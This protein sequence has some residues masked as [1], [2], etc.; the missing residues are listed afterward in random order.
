MTAAEY[1]A[2]PEDPDRNYELQDGFVIVSAKPVPNHQHAVLEL[3]VQLREQ[4]PRHLQV[5]VDVD[6]DLELVPSAQPGTVRA[7]DLV[8]IS[9]EA[10]LRVRRDGGFLRAAQCVLAVEVHSTS[11]RRTDQKVKRAE[12]ADAGIGHYW[13]VDLLGGPCLTACH[14]GGP[15]GYV[16]EGPVTGAF[17]TQ[18]PFPAHLDLTALS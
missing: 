15:F 12:Y 14:S 11:T 3:A 5:L 1:D 6:L 18:H 13:M 16:D 10:F 17:T 8:V 7:P 4:L 9:R 2:L